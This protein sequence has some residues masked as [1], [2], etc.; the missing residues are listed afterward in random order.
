MT[1]FEDFSEGNVDNGIKEKGLV[2]MMSFSKNIF[3]IYV[4]DYV[5][6]PYN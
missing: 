6:L 3:L 4:K 5:L 2:V 1:N